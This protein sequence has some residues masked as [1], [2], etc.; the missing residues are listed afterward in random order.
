M[1]LDPD[2]PHS[3]PA[4]A[5]RDAEGLVQ[6]SGGSRRRRCRRARDRPTIAFRFAPSR[7]DLPAMPVGD[8]ANLAHGLFKRRHGS[9]GR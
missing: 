2:R 8:L 5:M 6:V 9:R 4:A 3:R 7:L 1:R